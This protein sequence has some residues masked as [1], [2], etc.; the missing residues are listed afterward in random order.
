MFLELGTPKIAEYVSFFETV[1]GYHV[2][3]REARYAE[4]VTD[5]GED[6]GVKPGPGGIGSSCLG[7]DPELRST[8]NRAISCFSGQGL[9]VE[10]GLVVGDLD[11]AYAAAVKFKAWPISTGIVRRPWGVRDFRVLAPEAGIAVRI[12]EG[13]KSR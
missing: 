3:R 2:N 1:G 4:L 7:R 8:R 5:L 6:C 12:T 11:K 9:G 10:I 13:P